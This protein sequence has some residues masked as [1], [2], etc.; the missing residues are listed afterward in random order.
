MNYTANHQDISVRNLFEASLLRV[1]MSGARWRHVAALPFN[2]R[3][4]SLAPNTEGQLWPR[5]NIAQGAQ[6]P[7]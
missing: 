1:P 2:V 5:G 3:S 7:G 4:P 6:V